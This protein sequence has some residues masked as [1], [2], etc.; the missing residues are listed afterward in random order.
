MVVV[1]M[2]RFLLVFSL[3]SLFFLQFLVFSIRLSEQCEL[4][5][6]LQKLQGLHHDLANA[7]RPLPVFKRAHQYSPV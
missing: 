4:K 6:E 3:L 1:A 7:A 5:S 2:L